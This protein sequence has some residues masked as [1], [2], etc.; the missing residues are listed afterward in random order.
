[1]SR[2]NTLVA[3]GANKISSKVIRPFE[4]E[5]GA[6][7]DTTRTFFSEFENEILHRALKETGMM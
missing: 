4:K 2:F 5:F 6:R 1:M 7:I 3:L